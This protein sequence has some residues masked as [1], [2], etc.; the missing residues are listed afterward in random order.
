MSLIL[1]FCMYYLSFMPLWVTV[2]F[3]DIKSL[4]EGRDY[5]GTET[6][7]I[8][9]I[10]IFLIV[11]ILYMLWYFN[12]FNEGFIEEYEIVKVKESKMVTA[13]FLLSYILPLFAFDFCRWDQV[14][15][16]LV[17]FSVLGFL[18]IRHNYFSV[19]IILEIM[20]FRIYECTLNNRD[21][22]PIEK[23]VISKNLLTLKKGHPIKLKWLNNEV[24][25]DVK[26]DK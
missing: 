3:I 11:T 12:R 4:I 23:I 21:E 5:K 8:V 26:K 2:L 17:F 22:R 15:E 1:S 24:M 6:L 10:I 14:V 25:L 13:E 7:S 9:L 16:F 19:N 20:K 18:C